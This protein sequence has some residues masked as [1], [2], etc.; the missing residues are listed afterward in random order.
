MIKAQNPPTKMTYTGLLPWHKTLAEKLRDYDRRTSH[1][2]IH[3]EENQ[4][5][6]AFVK[7][8]CTHENAQVY[9]QYILSY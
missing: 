9:E 5:K 6:Y 7:Y 8:M 3:C 1:A 2:L 4:A